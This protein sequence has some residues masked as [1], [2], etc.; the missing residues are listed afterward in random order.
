VP[1]VAVDIAPV[2]SLVARVME[3]VGTPDLVIQPQAS[4]HEYSLRPSEAASLQDAD[5]VFWIGE[6]LTPWME[7]AVETLATNAKVT[8][9][10]AVE[11]TTLLDFREGALFEAH[12]HGD[13]DEHAHDDHE[14]HD[15]HGHEDHG[16]DD[17]AEDGH[18]DHGHDDHAEADDHDHDHDKHDHA[19]EDA[20][21]DHDKEEHDH[22]HE[23]HDHGEHDPHA[24]LSPENA[25]VWLN[26]IAAELSA[27]DPE[28][29]GAYF[30]NAAAARS[31]LETL[32]T[33]VAATLEPVRGRSFV[34]F[35]D[36]Y[37]YF[38]VAFDFPA[39]GAITLGDASDA[40][41]ARI[42]EIQGRIRDEGVHCVLAEPQYDAGLVATVLDGTDAKTG[43]IDPIGATYAPG[44]ELYGQIVRGMAET[45]SECLR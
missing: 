31:E 35:H 34:V 25:A 21:E 23:G 37:Q 30:A 8:S 18:D 24:W 22:A 17:H 3:G 9:L 20:H 13:E 6:D 42:A 32:K 4:P 2:H 44:I 19:S 40:S 7:D 28:N 29:A 1:S 11:D 39:A 43:V 36:A 12:D 14:D 26:V 38:E 10:L 27:F 16:H 33:D 5:I 45:L 15:D 41:P